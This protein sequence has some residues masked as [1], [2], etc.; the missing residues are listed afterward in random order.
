MNNL[1]VEK[2]TMLI[3]IECIIQIEGFRKLRR[4]L[5]LNAYRALICKGL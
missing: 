3:Q 1:I 4:N 5:T 2:L